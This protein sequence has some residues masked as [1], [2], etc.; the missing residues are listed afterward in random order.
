MRVNPS[1]KALKGNQLSEAEKAKIE[2]ITH[3]IALGIAFIG[4]YIFFFKILF[5]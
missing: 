2:K 5:F 4:T 3:K 1:P